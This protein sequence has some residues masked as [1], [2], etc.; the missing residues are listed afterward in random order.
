ML[1]YRQEFVKA[2]LFRLACL[3]RQV[4][5][6]VLDG[7]ETRVGA[8]LR[9]LCIDRFRQ[10]WRF[11]RAKQICQVWR[12]AREVFKIGQQSRI[13]SVCVY[14]SY[15]NDSTPPHYKKRCPREPP[16]R[17]NQK[18][19]P[20]KATSSRMAWP[21]SWSCR[22]EQVRQMEAR[23]SPCA[24]RDA[25]RRCRRRKRYLSLHIAG[26]AV[27]PSISLLIFCRCCKR[28]S[29]FVG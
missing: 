15:V 7:H 19:R 8:A 11:D 12:L 13:K 22:I 29:T 10:V 26:K 1:K 23:R 5:G 27:L 3:G 14:L 20:R 17:L 18:S 21:E 6:H 24:F 4:V 2:G 9:R 16:R 25:V 28:S